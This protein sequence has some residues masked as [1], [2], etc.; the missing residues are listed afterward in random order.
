[1]NNAMAAGTGLLFWFI[2]VRI[3]DIPTGQIG[4]GYSIIALGTT[5]ALVAKGGLDTALLR[6]V[7]KASDREGLRL[8][9]VGILVGASAAILLSGSLAL[10]A[11]TGGPLPQLARW[12]WLL[13]AIIAMLMVGTSL[14]DAW[15]LAQGDARSTFRRNVVFSS[16]RIILPLPILA[17]APPEPVPLIWLLALIA[18]TLTGIALARHRPH[19]DGGSVPRRAFLGCALRNITSSAAEFLPG[20]LLVPLVL[21]TQGPAAA[22]YFGMA[23]TAA[24]LLLLGSATIGRSALTSMVRDEPP[25]TAVRRA[26]NQALLVLGPVAVL[27]AL[28]A[29][30]V[31]AIFGTD[32]ATESA[33]SFAILCAST[34]FVA[35]SFLY[36]AYLRARDRPATLLL[37]PLAM[38]AV[39]FL[40]APPLALLFG[41]A[42]VALAW[43][44]ANAPFG[45]FA[46]WRLSRI[47]KEV[48]THATPNL[49]GD[50]HPE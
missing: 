41:L 14:Q 26:A 20:L 22:G 45:I 42:G 36:L 8:L 6:N 32:Y 31:M 5:V 48:T 9:G 24:A 11:S 34:L 30:F 46:L 3:A 21:A 39:L 40:L 13:V 7:P 23:W 19:H 2:M 29:R 37:F 33:P 27:G 50:P 1:M 15:F 38:I 17:L 35:P 12:G 43:L 49:C 25:A 44:L 18:A 28:L 10:A 47:A 4:V 16:A